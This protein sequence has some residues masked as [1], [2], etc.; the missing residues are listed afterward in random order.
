MWKITVAIAFAAVL[1]PFASETAF[2]RK[3]LR[4]NEVQDLVSGKTVVWSK[5]GIYFSPDGLAAW[6]WKGKSRTGIL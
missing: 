2:A 4:Q 1:S 5:G 3:V 6:V